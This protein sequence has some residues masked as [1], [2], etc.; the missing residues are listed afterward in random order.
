MDLHA[1]DMA[2]GRVLDRYRENHPH[3]R[4]SGFPPHV[5]QEKDDGIALVHLVAT[6]P[7]FMAGKVA[8]LHL[9]IHSSLGHVGWL[10]CRGTC[11]H[12]FQ[13]DKDLLEKGQSWFLGCV[14]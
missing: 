8:T 9:D 4:I 5:A 2:S 6:V 10:S 3:F 13:I 7:I 11:T 1:H 12:Q 14:A